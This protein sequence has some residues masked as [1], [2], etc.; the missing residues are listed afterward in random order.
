MPTLHAAYIVQGVSA[1]AR[2]L[3]VEEGERVLGVPSPLAN[4]VKVGRETDAAASLAGDDVAAAIRVARD[5]A[6]DSA[7]H[8]TPSIAAATV[9]S[10]TASAD[11]R[12]ALA[13]RFAAV[14]ALPFAR[15][16]APVDDALC[17][18]LSEL[19][20]ARTSIAASAGALISPGDA[21]LTA[22][23]SAT[24]VAALAAAAKRGAGI[25]IVIAESAP[26]LSGHAAAAALV[27]SSAASRPIQRTVIPD[28]AVEAVMPRIHKVGRAPVARSPL[29]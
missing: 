7:G 20:A 10:G 15:I 17:E 9:A 2:W 22:G 28:A 21:V 13:S 5:A 18:L 25:D 3:I 1:R 29:V 6:V 23:N 4:R 12:N 16:R 19:D 27:R 24:A 14:R 8:W 11:A 26:S